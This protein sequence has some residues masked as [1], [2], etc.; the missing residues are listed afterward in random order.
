MRKITL[1][2]HPDTF[3][4][5][6]RHDISHT[7]LTREKQF[8]A[9][10]SGPLLD[11]WRQRQEGEFLGVDQV[12]IRFV[13]FVDP[14]HQQVV[15]VISGRAESYIKY[16]E[17][18]YDLFHQGYDVVMMDHRGQGFSGR[19]LA[20]PQRGHVVHFEHYIDDLQQF[21]QQEVMARAYQRHFALAHSLGVAILTRFLIKHPEAFDAVALCAPMFGIRLHMPVWLSQA[22]L[23]WAEKSPKRRDDYAPGTTHWRPIPYLINRL[24]HSRVR[25]Q[26]TLRHS[27]DDP[28]L[29]LGGPTYHWVKESTQAGKQIIAQAAQLITPFILLQASEEKVV[30]NQ[31]HTAFFQVRSD[32]GTVNTGATKMAEQPIVIQG[33]RHEILFEQDALRTTALTEI[34]QFFQQYQKD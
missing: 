23:A 6:D 33:A 7:L 17:L 15:M 21:W 26:R 29:Q 10:T 25:Y 4:P 27:A 22:I 31:A 1:P 34:L 12:P 3:T 18:A 20:D 16:Q 11:F 32:A 5:I 24:T 8:A 19:M 28:R 14:A 13:R 9:F 30:D 2:T